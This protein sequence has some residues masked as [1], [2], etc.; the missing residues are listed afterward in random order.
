MVLGI[1][2]LIFCFA[3]GLVLRSGYLGC[4]FVCLISSVRRFR[5]LCVVQVCICV[6][7]VE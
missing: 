4:W 6:P 1:S 2:G 3:C 7:F 5:C